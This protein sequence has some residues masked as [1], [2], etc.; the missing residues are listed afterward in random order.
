ML[1]YLET[2]LPCLFAAV[3][4]RPLLLVTGGTFTRTPASLLSDISRCILIKKTLHS[5][6]SEHMLLWQAS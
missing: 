4:R 2:V 6:N 5:Q 3:G 1:A